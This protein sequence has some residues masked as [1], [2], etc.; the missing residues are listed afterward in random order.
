MKPPTNNPDDVWEVLFWTTLVFIILV[1]IGCI[2][3][4]EPVKTIIN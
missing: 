4:P 1:V 2:M 3:N